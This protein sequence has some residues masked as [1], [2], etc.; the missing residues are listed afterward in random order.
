MALWDFFRSKTSNGVPE[1]TEEF[2]AL[3]MKLDPLIQRSIDLEDVPEAAGGFGA[4]LDNAR[5]EVDKFRVAAALSSIYTKV[6]RKRSEILREIERIRP[7]YMAQVIVDQIAEDSLSPDVT[8]GDVITVTSDDNAINTHLK[9]FDEDFGFDKIVN[10]I[11]EDLVAY[12]EWTLRVEISSGKGI[13][14]IFDDVEQNQVISIPRNGEIYKY[15]VLDD[16]G[17]AK[18]V[19]PNEYVKF[20]LGNG[21]LR[22]DLWDDVPFVNDPALQA[23]AVSAAGGRRNQDMKGKVPRYVRMGKSMLYP[24][25]PKIKELELLE[26]LVPASKIAK[27]SAGTIVGVQ[28]P[29]AFDIDK[30][31]Q[32]A[33]RVEGMLNK[34][35]GLDQTRKEMTVED[36]ISAAGR[37]KVA[38]VFGDKG[39]LI[40]TDY[41]PEEPD[42][43]LSAIED[44]RRTICSAIGIPYEIIFGG[45][46]TK[47]SLLKRYARYVRRLK[48]F[49]MAITEGVRQMVEIHLVNKSLS[50]QPDKIKIEFRNKLI[51][52]DVLDELEYLDS[53]VGMLRDVVDFLIGG[54]LKPAVD[55]K[56]L[57][58][59]INNRFR[60]LGLNKVIDP[61]KWKDVMGADEEPDDGGADNPPSGPEEPAPPGPSSQPATQPAGTPPPEGSPSGTAADDQAA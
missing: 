37:I 39:Q 14:G 42:D 24:I 52:V 8:T 1:L 27:L 51:Q 38:P 28:V 46:E 49:Q 48:A 59:Y 29:A 25:I 26:S 12:G 5:Q 4:R 22:V 19:E 60:L 35:L 21:K 30:A 31:F 2:H 44:I 10:D 57:L 58:E 33:R 45:Q 43:L 20:M 36:I 18:L 9:Q 13:T 17:K 32:A 50:F 55:G 34:K 3:L 56:V 7:F 41:K 15:L 54:P 61:S 40:K 6:V 16:S 23:G 47:G 53:T 11:K